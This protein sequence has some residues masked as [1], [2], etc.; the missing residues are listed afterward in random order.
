M[1]RESSIEELFELQ[2]K[3]RVFRA[4]NK[5]NHPGLISH[6]TQR[7]AGREPLFLEKED[8]AIMLWLIK[9]A[10]ERFDLKCYALCLMPNHVHLLLET[11]K[12]NLAEAMH[13]IFARY[14]M[15][16]NR[17]YQRRGHIFG[18]A[19]R[20]AVCLDNSYLLTASV[21]IH[22]NPVRAGL[23]DRALDYRWSSCA[24]YCSNQADGSFVDPAL[25]LS[26]IDPDPQLAGKHYAAMLDKGRTCPAENV[27]EQETAI[28]KLVTRMADIFPWLYRKIAQQSEVSRTTGSTVLEQTTLQEMVRQVQLGRPRAAATRQARQY[29]AEQLLARGFSRTQIAQKLG[30]S[31]K[32]VYTMLTQTKKTQKA[33]DAQ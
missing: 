16:F 22:L 30:V 1:D 31:R 19:Y 21:Y 17:K 9:D 5:L 4:R 11:Q 27:M 28:Q 33:H 13:S 20:Q 14:G 23:A 18:G 24:L 3:H 25:I 15:R 2:G 7:A 8:Y 26:L 6:I 29:L 32:T 10:A 12:A